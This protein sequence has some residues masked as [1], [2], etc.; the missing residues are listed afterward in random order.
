MHDLVGKQNPILKSEIS[1]KKL[2]LFLLFFLMKDP[3][4]PKDLQIQ[5]N[6]NTTSVLQLLLSLC[7]FTTSI[8]VLLYNWVNPET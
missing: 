3:P 4:N 2:P 7:Q 1:K 5:N 6:R 8:I